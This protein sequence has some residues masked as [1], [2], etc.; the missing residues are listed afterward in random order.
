MW[1]YIGGGVGGGGIQ[2]LKNKDGNEKYKYLPNIVLTILPHRNADPERGFFIKKI[3]LEKHKK[4]IDKDTLESIHIV[5]D[6]IIDKVGY[7]NVETTKEVT[8][9]CK[10]LR[11]SY[12]RYLDNK[13]EIE[14]DQLKQ[15]DTEIL[16][17]V[18][19]CPDFS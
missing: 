7:L 3:L 18:P 9:K 11:S 5:K 17:R 4:N 6:Y 19:L 14:K 8:S 2:C 1:N 10:S 13:R 15:R 16:S 12:Q